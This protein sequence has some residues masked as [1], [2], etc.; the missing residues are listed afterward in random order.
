MLGDETSGIADL[1][2]KLPICHVEVLLS[3]KIMSGLT[4][5]QN[6]MKYFTSNH[7]FHFM[8]IKIWKISKAGEISVWRDAKILA[9]RSIFEAVSLGWSSG[10]SQFIHCVFVSVIFIELVSLGWFLLL[11][12]GLQEFNAGS[13]LIGLCF[14]QYCGRKDTEIFGNHVDSFCCS[15]HKWMDSHSCWWT[16]VAIKHDGPWYRVVNSLSSLK[17]NWSDLAPKRWSASCTWQRSYA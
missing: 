14:L 9:R 4:D 15:G 10:K 11:W 6:I 2:E 8:N 1:R 12:F 3:C 16:P 5:G 7:L 13:R 17:R